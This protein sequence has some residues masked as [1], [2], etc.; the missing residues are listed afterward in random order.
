MPPKIT[1]EQQ[2]QRLYDAPDKLVR[3]G[4]PIIDPFREAIIS[5]NG[6]GYV[7]LVRTLRTLD[8]KGEHALTA[9][10]FHKGLQLFGVNMRREDVERYF[11]LQDRQNKTRLSVEE[12]V[13]GIRP[14]M[15][16]ARRDLV[17]QAFHQL[18]V[19]GTGQLP[20]E[21]LFSLYDAQ[22]HPALLAKRKTVEQVRSEFAQDWDRNHGG[23]IT[24]PM[25]L[26]YYA[27]ISSSTDSDD[28]FELMVRNTWHVSGGEGL[29]RCTT[30]AKV[31]V[32]F[33]DGR[34]GVFELKN[35][36]RLNRGNV[37]EIRS[38]LVRQGIKNIKSVT[39]LASP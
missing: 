13:R 32:V 26:E 15:S 14:E 28:F 33:E 16:M 20:V 3:V 22:G 29:A 8:A 30:C 35:D 12:F 7:A 9:E 31:E 5:R 2:L 4:D 34:R 24:L 36:L 17:L 19:R 38:A 11:K 39:A 23:T 6:G 37:D 21:D 1:P 27:N 10:E 18:D 25:F